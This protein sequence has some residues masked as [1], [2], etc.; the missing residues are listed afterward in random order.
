MS[1]ARLLDRLFNGS[2]AVT[3]L[4][5][6]VFGGLFALVSANLVHLVRANLDFLVET[7]W[8]GL[9]E[10]GALQ[11][12]ELVGLSY[13]SLALYVLFKGCLYGLLARFQKH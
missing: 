12:F 2:F 8:W 5:M 1:A 9:T 13:V 6:G 3:F 11:I 4:M 10:G 7:G